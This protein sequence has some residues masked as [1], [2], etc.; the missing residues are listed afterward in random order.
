MRAWNKSL[1]EGRRSRAFLWVP[2]SH[3]YGHLPCSRTNSNFQASLPFGGVEP[4][5][6]GSAIL[7]FGA[8]FRK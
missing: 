7:G 6:H 5:L 8:G 2:G 4:V 3:S 1:Q